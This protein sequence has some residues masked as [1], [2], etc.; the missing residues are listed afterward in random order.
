MATI[1]FHMVIIFS[2]ILAL[3]FYMVIIMFPTVI[4]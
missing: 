1:T 3:M 2:R 4:T